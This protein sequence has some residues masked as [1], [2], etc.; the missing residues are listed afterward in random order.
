MDSTKYGKL[1]AG[2]EVEKIEKMSSGW[3]KIKYKGQN[4]Y[5]L[6]QNLTNIQ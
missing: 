2:T 5:V 4:A 1:E 6:T 3:T